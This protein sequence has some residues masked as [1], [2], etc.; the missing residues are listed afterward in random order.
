MKLWNI[1]CDHHSDSLPWTQFSWGI[2]VFRFACGTHCEFVGSENCHVNLYFPST[3]YVQHVPHCSV[4][5]GKEGNDASFFINEVNSRV[6][7][8]R[9]ALVPGEL[10]PSDRFS[11]KLVKIRSSIILTEEVVGLQ[12]SPIFTITQP[13][14]QLIKHLHCVTSVHCKSMV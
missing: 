10:V 2:F 14:K 13:R 9:W 11:D 6:S 5:M 12:L 7:P 3:E 8:S 4:H 1:L